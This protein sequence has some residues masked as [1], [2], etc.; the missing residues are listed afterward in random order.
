LGSALAYWIGP[1]DP[2][3][4]LAAAMGPTARPGMWSRSR[5]AEEYARRSGRSVEG[6]AF[7]YC[8]GLFKVAVIVQQIYARYVRG[9]TRD[10]RFAPMHRIVAV[11]AR[12]AARA[13]EQ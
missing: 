4:L 12:Q 8:F 6:I 3:E 2:P 11:L 1:D 7:Y 9:Q 5:L 13:A 10:P